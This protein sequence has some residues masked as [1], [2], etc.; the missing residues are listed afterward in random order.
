MPKITIDLSEIEARALAA[1]EA[2]DGKTP[3]ERFAPYIRDIVQNAAGINLSARPERIESR[4]AELEEDA[5]EAKTAREQASEKLTP[6][7]D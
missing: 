5:A 1:L 7:V 2:L 4:L 6:D 3:N